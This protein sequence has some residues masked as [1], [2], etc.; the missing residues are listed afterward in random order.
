MSRLSSRRGFLRTTLVLVTGTLAGCADSLTDDDGDV[1]VVNEDGDDH[2]VTVTVDRGSGYDATSESV[3]VGAGERG[4]IASFIAESDWEY[5]LLLHVAID[6]EHVATTKH[7]GYDDVTLTVSSDGGVIT[8]DD[9]DA[10][11][12]TPREPHGPPS[13]S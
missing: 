12:T 11:P 9:Q 7:M 5:P 3:S 13:N 2:D 8:T 4:R 10:V 1:V 6:G